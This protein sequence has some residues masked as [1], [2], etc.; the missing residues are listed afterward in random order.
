MT[1]WEKKIG[2]I[3]IPTPFPVGDVNSFVLKGEALTLVDIGPKTEEAREALNHGLKQLK[4]ELRDIDQV[5][6]THHH[7]DHIGGLEFLPHQIPIVG[8]E[9]NRRWMNMNDDFVELYNT[10][11]LELAKKMGLPDFYYRAITKMEDEE[12]GSKN[13]TLTQLIKEGDTIS[14]ADG[15]I[16]Y[17]TPGHAQSHIVLFHEQDGALIAGDLLLPK[18]SP[19]PI[20]EP[21]L[22]GLHRPKSQLQL[23]KSLRRLLELPLKIAYPGHG[24]NIINPNP[25]IHKRLRA[26]HE[27]AMKVKAM[28]ED[29]PSTVFEICKQLFP[30]VYEKQLGLTLSETLAQF[31]YL[32]D[33]NEIKSEDTS[34]GLVF[35]PIS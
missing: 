8:H 28:L 30:K 33:L 4:L 12:Y 16:V 5:V 27:R 29:Q 3:E 19:N 35:Y 26:Q 34:Q 21:P 32:V 7:P 17:E 1:V 2:K 20:I 6:I 10:F 23:N 11:Y 13:R 14:G 24:E 15:W 18:I 25:L 22:D 31:D 9:Y